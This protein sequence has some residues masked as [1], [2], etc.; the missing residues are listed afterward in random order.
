MLYWIQRLC[1]VLNVY[2]INPGL[3]NN[4]KKNQ[5]GHWCLNLMQNVVWFVKIGFQTTGFVLYYYK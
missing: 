1:C 3:V 4:R 2:K 5:D